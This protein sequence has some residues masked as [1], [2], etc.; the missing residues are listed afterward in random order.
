MSAPTVDAPPPKVD[1]HRHLAGSIRLET[2]LELAEAHDLP[3]P[4][5]LEALRPL[6]QVTAP[7]PD[8]AGFLA[9]LRPVSLALVAPD[10]WARVAH[11]VVEDAAE[12]SIAYLELRFGPAGRH[13]P[14]AVVEAT[15]DGAQRGQRDYGVRVNLIGV[16]G[17]ARPTD[18]D[19]ALRALLAY[20]RHIV[21]LDLAGDEAGYPAR[22]FRGQ[23]TRARDA[24]WRITAHAGEAAGPASVWE[25]IR[26]LGAA[27]IGHA[28][29]A[30]EDERLMDYLAEH[31]IGLEC[32]LTSNVQVGAVPD[33][34]RHPLRRFLERGLLATIN[35]DDPVTSGVTLGHELTVAAPAAG[36][37]PAQIRQAQRNA[38]AVAFVD[39]EE[40]AVLR[41]SAGTAATTC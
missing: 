36:L 14:E 12:E 40:R 38:F 30:I 6:A 16:L 32:C 39:E 20:R 31:G 25:A 15:I 5:T 3:L 33:Y 34:S 21:G 19:D 10:I 37:S 28:T 27:R 29:R 1:L 18:A 8:L 9:K 35:T 24:S 26:E 41:T 22:P 17:R 23:F 13:P 11:E 7:L 2:I 4:R